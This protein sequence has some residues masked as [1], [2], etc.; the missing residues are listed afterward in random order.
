M[1]QPHNK[2]WR[3]DG[4]KALVTGATKGIGRAVAEELLAM[5]AEVCI[6][7]R[8]AAD[9][10]KAVDE[11]R[12]AGTV[13]GIAADVSK[14]EG[15]AHV[16]REIA[17]RWPALDVLVNNTGTNIRKKFDD[18]SADDL[19]TV[20]QT[21]LLS[22][23]RLTQLCHSLLRKAGH[24]SVVNVASIAARLDVKSGAPYGITKAGLVQ[25][26]RHLA[27]EWA[28]EGIRVN[29]V[30]PWYTR[31][32][33]ARPVLDNPE[34]LDLILRRTPLA[35]IAEPEEVASAVV[36]LCL[37]AASYITGQD[38]LVDGGMSANGL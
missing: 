21:N 20:L 19:E 18:Y 24:A 22:A 38:L 7:A 1:E 9:V 10:E 16:H 3:L 37:P 2:R 26:T 15:V 13:W 35:R 30:S 25:M 8:T 11:M 32:P 5:G 14:A 4:K 23:L 6:V 27:V 31:T 36:F 29:S 28:G 17:L 33:L 34:R 12:F